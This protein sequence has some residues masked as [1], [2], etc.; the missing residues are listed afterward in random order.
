MSRL[1]WNS[2]SERFYETGVD[3][4]VLYIANQAGIAWTGLTSVEEA[5]NGGDARPYYIDGIKFL[6]IAAAEEFEATINAFF[7]PP[8]FGPCDGISSVQNGLFATQQ[9]RKSFGLSYRTLIGNDVDGSG[10]AYKIHLVYNAL[11]AP[12]SRSN[13][14]IGDSAEPSMFS[15]QITTLPPALTG[16]KPTAHFVID[17]RTTSVP[18]LTRIENVLYG[19]ESVAPR[20]P[21]PAELITLYIPPTG[22]A[23]DDFARADAIGAV[24]V[25]NGWYGG[26]GGDANIVGGDLVRTDTGNYRLFLNPALGILP[27]DYTVTAIVP[28]AMVGVGSNFWGLVGRWDGLNGVRAMFTTGGGA[29]EIGDASGYGVNNVYADVP[30]M[31]VGWDNTAIDHTISMRMTGEQIEFIFDGTVIVTTS[32]STN[33]MKSGMG[34]GI[35]GEGNNRAWRSIGTTVP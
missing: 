1:T 15:W 17:S 20:L 25:G 10:H 11:A 8:E 2:V 9:P 28:G 18:I 16:Y 35:C 6:N 3:R 4:G 14:T 33:S 30:V 21:T 5:P 34:Y 29:I 12:S 24:A 32:C 31:P 22:V 23:F 7:S 26:I 19:T 13:N 27:T